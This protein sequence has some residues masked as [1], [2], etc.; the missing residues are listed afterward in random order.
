[1]RNLQ[2]KRSVVCPPSEMLKNND[3]EYLTKCF[4]N[5]S[6]GELKTSSGSCSIACFSSNPPLVPDP[7]KKHIFFANRDVT[8]TEPEN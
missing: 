6:I 3:N 4:D 8:F 2:Q 5:R 7:R 1:M